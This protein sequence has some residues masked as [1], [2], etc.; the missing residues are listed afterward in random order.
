MMRLDIEV[1]DVGPWKMQRD[2]N[3][4]GSHGAGTA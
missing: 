1:N 4:A 3:A 2:Q